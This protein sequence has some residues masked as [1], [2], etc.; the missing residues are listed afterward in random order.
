MK[1][2]RAVLAVFCAATLGAC[3][4]DT[5]PS[6]VVGI[7]WKVTSLQRTGSTRVEITGS[8]QRYTLRLNPDGTAG[9]FADCNQC[10]ARFTLTE[11]KLAITLEA[12]T[13]IYCGTESHEDAYLDILEGPGTL[14]RS[15]DTLVLQSPQGTLRFRIR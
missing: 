6:D 10:G 8:D 9:L 15:G 11:N 12:C 13:L 1:A 7:E 4:N 3:G 2:I 5:G 14:D